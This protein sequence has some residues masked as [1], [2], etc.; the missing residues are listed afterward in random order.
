VAQKLNNQIGRRK[1]ASARVILQ[2]AVKS[3]AVEGEEKTSIVVVNGQPLE[4]YFS[5]A[6]QQDQVL[7]PLVLADRVST[8]SVRINVSGGGKAGQAG[9]ARLGIAR[10]IQAQEPELRGALKAAGYLTRDPRS[11]E[12]KKAGKHKARKSTQFSKR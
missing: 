9:A 8:Y 10:A 7:A 1:T 2:S 3:E 6:S 4:K 12:R 11:V 5:V